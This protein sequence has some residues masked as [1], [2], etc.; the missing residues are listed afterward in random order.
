LNDGKVAAS[1]SSSRVIPRYSYSYCTYGEKET[2]TVAAHVS[3]RVLMRFIL[4]VYT[5][6]SEG[7][8]NGCGACVYLR[9]YESIIS[10]LHMLERRNR[11]RLRRMC[12][13]V[14]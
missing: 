12:L 5:C 11:E 9:P 2:E 8:R 13:F 6:W 10:T 3:I 1:H 7:N 4:V 14:S